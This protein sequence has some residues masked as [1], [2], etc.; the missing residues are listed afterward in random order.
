MD[1]EDSAV[2]RPNRRE[3]LVG[4]GAAGVVVGT[5]AFGGQS[6]AR[7]AKKP[8][9][10]IV[11]AGLAGLCAAYEL[12]QRG[13]TC[14]ILEAERRV[15]G[16]VRTLRLG[17]SYWEAGAM[18]IPKPHK[19]VRT[20]A[21]KFG[22]ELRPFIMYSK[23]TFK[24]ARNTKSINE[25]DIRTK[26]N[27]DPAEQYLSSDDLWNRSVKDV[28]RGKIN[29]V[30]NPLSE[31]EM[32]ELA[33][34]T[35]FT[36]KGL[37]DLDRLSLRQLIQ[38]ARLDN[39]AL[40]S[41]EAIEFTLFA[42]GYSTIQHAAATEFLREEKIGVWKPGFSEI[43]GGCQKLP[44]AFLSRLT[45]EPKYG[46][47]VFRLEQDK[48]RGRVRAI[49]RR[50]RSVGSEE[51]DFLL[52]TVPFP[53]LATIT[54]EPPFSHEKRQAIIETAYD[55]G[56]K[57]ALLTRYRFW[58]KQ[59]GIFGGS[60][61]TDL[62]SGP[63]FYP[64]DNALD[65]DGEKPLNPMVSDRPGVLLA[66]YTW[67]QD[68]RRLAA[69]EPRR[70]IEFVI[71]QASQVHPQLREPGMI[72]KQATW[73]WDNHRWAGGAFALYQPGQFQRLHEHV[74]KPEDRIYFAGEHCSHSHSWMEGALES[75]QRAVDALVARAG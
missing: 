27:L 9:V 65:E 58:E 19:V 1:S 51:G 22:L 52:C 21:A 41:N 39:G 37:I 53:V 68:A 50:R 26:Y 32:N 54:A 24:Y 57:I 20:Y 73:A 3:I 49:Y 60:T 62:M 33:T 14:T 13:W 35:T 29:P 4:I 30:G 64:S 72:L 47:E 31:T 45:N 15:G 8:H 75:A 2:R 12:Q 5:D 16:R 42:T 25:A 71:E 34:A 40:L 43:K 59:H 7:P 28:A 23:R 44:E 38:S 11:G 63:I 56:T 70:R 74:I 6:A 61:Q 69:M 67:G 46:C 10:V 66:S 55:S 36:S 17:D 18:R 48:L